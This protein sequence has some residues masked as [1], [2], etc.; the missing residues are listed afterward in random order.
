MLHR[1]RDL[2]VLELPLVSITNIT[3]VHVR[4]EQCHL[5]IDILLVQHPQVTW[6]RL[7]TCVRCLHEIIAVAVFAVHQ[8]G[9][10]G[11]ALRI[12]N[13]Q[14]IHQLSFW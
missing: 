11:K 1:P 2:S 9:L 3:A 6:Y 7:L 14:H 5:S 10:D 8:N 13:S 12:T 4:G